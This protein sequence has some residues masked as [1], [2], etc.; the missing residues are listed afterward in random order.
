MNST[1]WRIASVPS[2]TATPPMAYP[3]R[4]N[5]HVASAERRRRSRSVPPC[6]MPKSAWSCGR[7]CARTHRASQRSV[8]SWASSVRRR[9]SGTRR[10]RAWRRSSDSVECGAAGGQSSKAMMMS[11]PISFCTRMLDSGPRCTREPSTKLRNVTPSS[12][13]SAVSDML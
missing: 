5:W 1:T 13:R 3:G 6:T 4:S 2:P 10:V 9:W 8:R 11:A 7:A 12:S